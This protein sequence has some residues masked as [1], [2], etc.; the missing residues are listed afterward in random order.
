MIKLTTNI[1]I[2]ILMQVDDALL[3]RLEKLSFLKVSDDKRE[4]MIGQL[5]EIVSFVDNLS[6][7]NTDG[8]DDKFAMDDSSTFLREDTKQNDVEIGKS[9]LNHY[10]I[11]SENYH[12]EYGEYETCGYLLGHYMVD[13]SL[14]GYKVKRKVAD[15]KKYKHVFL[16]HQHTPQEMGNVTHVGSCRYISFSEYSD[17]KRVLILDLDTNEIEEIILQLVIPMAVYSCDKNTNK[18]LYR[19]LKVLEPDT[20]VK[21]IFNDLEGYKFNIN[22]I[23]EWNEKFIDFK[24]E[25]NF[26]VNGTESKETKT[27]TFSNDFLKW[28]DENDIDEDIKN[29]LRKEVENVK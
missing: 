2:G 16:G 20:K 28:L 17:I 12:I 11:L 23:S 1:N 13:E 5:S 9:I 8:V 15:L 29:I 22:N 6:E 18:T 10:S 21:V 19:R 7:L 4:E 27:D 24:V 25:L 26:K 14:F 3:L